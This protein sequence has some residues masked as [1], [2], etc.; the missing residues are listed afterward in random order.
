MVAAGPTAGGPYDW[1]LVSG[2]AP[3]KK[4]PDGCRTGTGVNG[5]GLWAFTREQVADK[6][7]VDMIVKT[8]ADMGYDP[9]VLKPVEQVGCPAAPPL[10]A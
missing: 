5:S 4:F 7:T 1:A 9:T 6:A 2:G 8:A 10:F 3:T